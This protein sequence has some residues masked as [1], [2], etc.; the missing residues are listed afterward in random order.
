[1]HREVVVKEWLRRIRGAIGMGLTWA[2]AWAPVGLLIMLIVDPSDSMDEP[3]LLV[4]AY[5]GFIGGVL[6]SAVLAIAEGRRRFDE[7]S[8]SRVGAWG[9][10]AG[11]LLGL[12]PF[13]LLAAGAPTE[14]PLWLLGVVIIG[15]ITLLSAGSALGTLA[16]ARRAE[17]RELLDASRDVAQVGLNGDEAKDL[18]GSQG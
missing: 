11:L 8:L 18:L 13:A 10:A 6:F 14:L 16:L 5:P 7:L 4:G 15:P 2:L 12:L 9:A 3:W 1:M 17:E